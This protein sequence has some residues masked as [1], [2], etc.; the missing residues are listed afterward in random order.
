ML[1]EILIGVCKELN[2]VPSKERALLRLP[3]HTLLFWSNDKSIISLL[4]SCLAHLLF[5]NSKSPKP[6]ELPH[7]IVPSLSTSTHQNLF[8][9]KGL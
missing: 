6:L 2:C 9:P 7:Q 5:L 4:T 3:N 8:V 1:G